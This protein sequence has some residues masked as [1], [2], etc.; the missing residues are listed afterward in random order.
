M[1]ISGITRVAVTLRSETH[2]DAPKAVLT[3]AELEEHFA[4][5]PKPTA[6]VVLVIVG[7]RMYK[8]ESDGRFYLL[9]NTP[10]KGTAI[11]GS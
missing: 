2:V 1:S 8:R 6:S 5:G 3:Q 9:G 7:G 4:D 11:G 10:S